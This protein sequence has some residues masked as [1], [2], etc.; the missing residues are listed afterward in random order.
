ML[1]VVIPT[2]YNGI[3]GY[4]TA[5]GCGTGY[6]TSTLNILLATVTV[7]GVL[8]VVQHLFRSGDG[9]ADQHGKRRWPR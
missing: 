2:F 9:L 5:F 3:P 7:Q 8:V 6:S 1:S 4:D